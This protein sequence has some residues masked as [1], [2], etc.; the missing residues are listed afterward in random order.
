MVMVIVLDDD[1]ILL[2]D[3]EVLPVDFAENL[4]LEHLS[5]RRGGVEFGFEQNQ[6]IYARPDHI[7]VMGDEK[8]G[9]VQL[10]VQVLHQFDDVVLRRNIES[11]RRLVQQEDFRL[12]RQCPRNEHSLLLA[13]GQVSQRGVL[14]IIHGHMGQRVHRDFPILDP[15]AS[16]QA[17]RAVTAHHHGFEDRHREIAIDDAFLRQ[18]ADLGAMVAT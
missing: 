11:G 7:D 6:S 15:R 18:I 16:K 3:D 4:W 9:Q 2:G 13:S 1:Q 5:R 17:Q 8:Y 14:M 12:L 10:F